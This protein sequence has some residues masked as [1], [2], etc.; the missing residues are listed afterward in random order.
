[1]SDLDYSCS[2]DASHVQ[3]LTC[4]G[5]HVPLHIAALGYAILHLKALEVM[6]VLHITALEYVSYCTS[7]R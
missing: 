2:W 4:A 6:V 1:M 3:S 7:Q 5:A